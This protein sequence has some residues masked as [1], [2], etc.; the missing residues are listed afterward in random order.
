MRD[1]QGQPIFTEDYLCQ[2][3]WDAKTVSSLLGAGCH[4]AILLAM[5]EKDKQVIAKVFG[6]TLTVAIS[7]QVKLS[8]GLRCLVSSFEFL[9]WNSGLQG[10]GFLI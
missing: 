2:E 4:A 10:V 7:L 9:L 5:M 3:A 6:H 1:G 8:A